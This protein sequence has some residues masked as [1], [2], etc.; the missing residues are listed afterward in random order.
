MSIPS[1]DEKTLSSSIEPTSIEQRKQR[2]SRSSASDKPRKQVSSSKKGDSPKKKKNKERDRSPKAQSTMTQTVEN[3]TKDYKM[4]NLD[5]L[6][7]TY[8]NE[9]NNDDH[10]TLEKASI[11]PSTSRSKSE[12]TRKS[13]S[14]KTSRR[15]QSSPKSQT[16]S[17]LLT[18]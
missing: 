15:E 2:H 8:V 5:Y 17:H 1:S 12:S 3:M 18:K 7:T 4:D 11:A 6:E 14:K 10:Y 16:R 13:G 9:V